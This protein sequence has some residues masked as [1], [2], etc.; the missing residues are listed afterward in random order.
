MDIP[1]IYSPAHL[2][3]SPQFE[4]FE[5]EKIPHAEKKERIEEI[6]KTLIQKGYK[7]FVSSKSFPI[8]H[9]TKIHQKSY[10]EF[11]RQKS[12][13]LKDVNFELYP[14]Y[15]S[16]DTY[17]PILR[18]T[19][20]AAKQS[21]DVALT[22]A[23]L[24]QKGKKIAYGLCRPPGHH[25]DSNIMGGYCYF[26]NAAVAADYLSL[27]GR[28]AILD[29]DFHHG[30]GTQH[31]FY[32][33]SDVFYVSLHV[34][35]TVKFPYISGFS[36]ETGIGKGKGFTKNFPLPLGT[37]ENTYYKTLKKAISH[38]K[39]FNPD[40]LVVSLGFDTFENDPIGGFKLSIPFYRTIGKEMSYLNTPTLLI[41]E[42][43]YAVSSLGEMAHF[44]LKGLSL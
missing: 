30:N 39:K 43:G 41:Q 26:N 18:G 32:E 36:D 9:I 28:V 11:I 13:S 40:Y 24:I 19:F 15:Y 44:I 35:P 12:N 33:R 20:D 5:G 38:I 42:G 31:I 17:T 7:T 25:A 6:K 37:A 10:I 34:D 22:G 27:H 21:V 16:M 4:I 23:S 14:S 8:T 1:I 2:R 29:I 3:H